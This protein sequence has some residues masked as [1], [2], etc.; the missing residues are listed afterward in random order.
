[1]FLAMKEMG[2]LMGTFVGHD[3]VNNYIVDT[4][5]WHWDMVSSPDGGPPMSLK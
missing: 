3:H 2:D 1:M 4:T 5:V